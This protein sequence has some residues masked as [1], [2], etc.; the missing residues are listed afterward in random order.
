MIK[1]SSPRASHSM[2]HSVQ[3]IDPLHHTDHTDPGRVAFVGV[4]QRT[5]RIQHSAVAGIPHA[6]GVSCES[7]HPVPNRVDQG[8]GLG[9]RTALQL[10]YH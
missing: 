2:A 10:A 1:G 9:G 4:A 6:E 3:I 5:D 8:S 7:A